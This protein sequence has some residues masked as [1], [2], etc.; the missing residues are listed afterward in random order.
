MTD[1]G[2]MIKKAVTQGELA[3]EGSA[4]GMAVLELTAD[5]SRLC[6]VQTFVKAQLKTARC[7]E[8]SK[9]TIEIIVEE[10]F[11]NITSYAY[12]DSPGKVTV[13]AGLTDDESALVKEMVEMALQVNGK[14]R[15][16]F[17][18]V[19]DAPKE[20]V[21]KAALASEAIVPFVEGK[22][23]SKVIVVPNKIVNIV[24]N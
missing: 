11:V 19:Q 17:E 5:V 23:I 16:R 12:A 8:K 13:A 24:A 3:G 14:V 20:E 21:E 9:M 18:A 7:S 1:D 2:M 15:G 6:D 4:Q 22:T 10:I